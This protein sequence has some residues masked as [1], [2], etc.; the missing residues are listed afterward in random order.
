MLV[1]H[2]HDHVDVA[3]GVDVAKRGAAAPMVRSEAWPGVPD[4]SE[5]TITHVAPRPWI[6][7]PGAARPRRRSDYAAC[8]LKTIR[9][10]RADRCAES[11]RAAAWP[12]QARLSGMTPAQQLISESSY[13]RGCRRSWC[14]SSQVV[15]TSSG[16]PSPLRSSASTPMLICCLPDPRQWPPQR[17]SVRSSKVPLTLVEERG[18]SGPYRSATYRSGQSVAIQ[19]G[20]HASA[21]A[22]DARRG[23]D[24]GHFGHILERLQSPQFRKRKWRLGGDG[25]RRATARSRVL[26][27]AEKWAFASTGPTSV[28][29]YVRSRSPSWSSSS[30]RAGVD[31]P[32]ASR[33]GPPARVAERAV[34]AVKVEH[35]GAGGWSRKRSGSPLPS[36]SAATAPWVNPRNPTPPVRSRP[37]RCGHR[38]FGRV[39]F[40]ASN[41]APRVG[42]MRVV[43]K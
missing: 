22:L 43:P 16:R 6:A 25:R 32:A 15:T 2:T 10:G 34:A 33:S 19:V 7:R 24:T 29:S 20:G 41:P 27:V 5:T 13:H 12:T 26:R 38:G 36:K 1:H 39:G 14:D 18:N 21:P 35:D 31:N 3:V 37:R 17:A 23:M 30:G 9:S 28:G 11:A 40:R 42:S 8:P 4:G